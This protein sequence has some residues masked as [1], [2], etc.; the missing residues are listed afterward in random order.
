MKAIEQLELPLWEILKAATIAPN[1]A[2]L[3]Q[4]L[5]M[6]E[7]A[8]SNL[9]TVGQLRVAAEAIAQIVQVFQER[10][11]LAFEELE[12]TASDDGP[13]MP[14][15][16]F[17]RYV[18]QTMEVDFE[19]FIEPLESFPRKVRQQQ[20]RSDELR[21]VVGDLDQ[22]ALLQALDEQMSQHSGLTEVEAFN[23][24]MNI[25]HDEDVSTWTKTIA[26]CLQE[27]QISMIPLV[28]LQQAVRMPLVQLWLA[29]LLGG[30]TIE[31]RGEFY[32][33]ERIWVL[34]SG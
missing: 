15:D 6:L 17:D 13:V 21:S 33:A 31:Q 25:A 27:H 23:Q 2:D 7:G 4:L 8:L 12:A 34:A 18:R 5:D 30:F 9:D 1:E 22:T 26:Q 24:A 29:L 11:V 28:Q 16:A 14:L 32:E 19:Q 3:R 10:S 20:Q